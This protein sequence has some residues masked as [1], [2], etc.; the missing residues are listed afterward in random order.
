MSSEV[1]FF[2]HVVFHFGEINGEK[3]FMKDTIFPSDMCKPEI[4]KAVCYS[5]KAIF[6]TCEKYGCRQFNPW[7]KGV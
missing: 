5:H 3:D 2:Y 4:L 6:V 7:T 1:I